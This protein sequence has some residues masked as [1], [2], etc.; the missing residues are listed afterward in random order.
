MTLDDGSG[1][2][3]AL[4]DT[5][6]IEENTGSLS[7]TYA[8]LYNQSGTILATDDDSGPGLSL[9]IVYTFGAP[10]SNYAGP[11]FVRAGA[12]DGNTGSVRWDDT[13]LKGC[14]AS[15]CI[16]ASTRPGSAR[17]GWRPAGPVRP[18]P[19]R[20]RR[21][22]RAN[23]ADRAAPGAGR[24]P[25]PLTRAGGPLIGSPCLRASFLA[26]PAAR[27]G[28][29]RGPA[30]CCR[31]HVPSPE[32]LPASG[33]VAANDLWFFQVHGVRAEGSPA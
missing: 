16:S 1:T 28:R 13:G 23:R 27:S 20:P 7:D 10:N 3:V 32:R 31:E 15:I 21:P 26:L 33:E 11:Y 12:F 22:P 6:I 2:L 19:E 9:R 25:F 8:F 18:R 17:W 5:V 14:Y 24:P 4:G 30:V 29:R